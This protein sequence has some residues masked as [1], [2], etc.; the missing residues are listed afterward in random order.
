LTQL[1]ADENGDEETETQQRTPDLRITPRITKPTPLQAQKQ[2]NNSTNQEHRSHNI[3]LLQ[4]L[5]DRKM[6]V[7]PL[8]IRKEEEDDSQRH[9][10]KRK[11]NLKAPSPR[12]AVRERTS[13]DRS[14]DG[15]DAKHGGE[16]RNVNRPFPQRHRK[17]NDGHA[18]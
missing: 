15:C 6:R 12:R 1:Y 7:R 5:P 10:P 9:G 11:I 3:N 4:P 17:P 16:R 13:K 8:G 18:T 14:H 2:A